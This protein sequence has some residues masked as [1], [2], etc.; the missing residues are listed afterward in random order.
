[1][2]VLSATTQARPQYKIIFKPEIFPLS[3]R[4]HMQLEIGFG[5][6]EFTVQYAKNNPEI[7]LYGIE[8]SQSCVLRCARRAEGL[9]NLKIINTDAR[10]M[11]RELFED[12]SFEKIFMQFPCP[13]P[14]NGNA[15]RRVTA[16]DF[17]DGLAAVLKTGGVFEMVSDDKNYSD[18]VWRVLGGHEAL[19]AEEFITNPKREITTKYERKWLE[20]GKDIFRLTFRKTKKFTVERRTAQEMHIKIRNKIMREDVDTLKNISGRDEDKKSFW[21]FGKNFTDG[22]KFLLEVLSSDDEFEQ[23]FYINISP[24]DGGFLIRLDKT[25]GAFLTPAVRSALSD[26]AARLNKIGYLKYNNPSFLIPNS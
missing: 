15:H 16:K 12:E 1:M 7:F 26:A 4:D 3:I 18:E 11:L 25:S 2:D 9:S 10:Y 20:E 17:S 8:I 19:E 24:R 5:N 22:E 6:G 14:G 13:W 21:R 23:R